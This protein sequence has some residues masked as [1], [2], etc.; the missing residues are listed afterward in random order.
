MSSKLETSLNG[1]LFIEVGMTLYWIPD[2]TF[3]YDQ[4]LLR[5]TPITVRVCSLAPPHHVYCV[6][7]DQPDVS[8]A[9]C[10]IDRLYPTLKAAWERVASKLKPI[11][12][13]ANKALYNAREKAKG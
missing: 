13:D 12:D 4:T 9:P 11:V 7:V 10:S 2:V 5:C 1:L 6:S 8:P 3:D